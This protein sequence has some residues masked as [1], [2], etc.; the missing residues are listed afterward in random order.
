MNSIEF[1]NKMVGV[2]WENRAS[3]FESVDCWGLVLL[4]YKH[5]LNIELPQ[6]GG[7]L[8]REN[9]EKCWVI[10]SEKR[11]QEVGSPT[12]S[13]LVF[14]CYDS[15]LKPMHVGVCIDDTN[16]LHADG[17]INNGGSVRVNKISSLERLHG[18]VTYHTYTG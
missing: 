3:S 2:P 12:E 18:K 11:W 10:E 6:T 9:I 17:H 7:Y 4:Y 8:E 5:V 15:N 1:I 16:A 13:G 14:T